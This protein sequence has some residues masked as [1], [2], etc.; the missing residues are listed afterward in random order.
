MKT[1]LLTATLLLLTS[2]FANAQE[3][4]LKPTMSAPKPETPAVLSLEI[5]FKNSQPPAY[6]SVRGPETKPRW[7]WAARFARLPGVKPRPDEL[8]I[9]AIRVES[10]FNGETADVKVSLLRGRNGFDREDPVATYHIGLDEKTTVTELKSFGLEPIDLTLL[11]NV[12]PLPPAPD[13][14]NRTLS[15][16]VISVESNNVPLPTY[17]LTFRNQSLKNI[18]ALKMEII[19]DGR[20]R[21]SALWQNEFDR[22]IIEAGGTAEKILPAFIAQKTATAYAPG[23]GTNNTIVIGA[24]VFEDLTFDGDEEAACQYEKYVVGRRLWVKR[25]LPLIE[26]E[27]ANQALSPKEFKEKLLS[28]TYKL[29][30]SERTGSS[31]VSAKCEN[32]D[33]F[34]DI[35][36]KTQSLEL[37][38][39]LDR[40]I[41]TRPSPPI[42][43]RS[44]LETRLEN[45]KGW[46]TRLQ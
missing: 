30:D 22:P 12:P 31:A 10:Q 15:V 3:P 20:T 41:S 38:R 42:N 46:L 21:L 26:S 7:I 16:A 39:E 34:V 25:V 28:L 18:R 35:S 24:A 44:W 32:P 8:P 11:N 19:S 23:V 9:Q 17:K 33:S 36:T 29:E 4:S 40:I 37:L 13:F 1:F 2:S 43:F 27:L 14:E 6:I 45:Y 5:D